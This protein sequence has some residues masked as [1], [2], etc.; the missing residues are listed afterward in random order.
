[1]NDVM[2]SIRHCI[3]ASIKAYIND[4]M[5]RRRRIYQRYASSFSYINDVMHRLRHTTMTSYMREKRS[6]EEDTDRRALYK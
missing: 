6:A 3:H 1:M 5:H 4:V 2:H